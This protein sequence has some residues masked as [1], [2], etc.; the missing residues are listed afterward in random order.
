M[1]IHLGLRLNSDAVPSLEAAVTSAVGSSASSSP[2]TD[3]S[4]AKDAD[5]TLPEVSVL[6]GGG[7]LRSVA[8]KNI[9]DYAARDDTQVHEMPSTRIPLFNDDYF[10]STKDTMTVVDVDK[11]VSSKTFSLCLSGTILTLHRAIVEK[12]VCLGRSP[13]WRKTWIDSALAI[14]MQ[15]VF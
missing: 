10:F 3:P 15:E 7:Q 11:L 4:S 12:A 14:S 6:R 13:G 8:V 1:S 9:V 5:S 2:S